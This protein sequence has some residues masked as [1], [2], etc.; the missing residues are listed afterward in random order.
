MVFQGRQV[1]VEITDS[2]SGDPASR[3]SDSSGRSFESP[4]PR[5]RI[6]GDKKFGD[7][8]FGDKRFGDKKTE[9]FHKKWR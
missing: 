3:P 1:R 9:R 2:R 7:K 4:R 5:K 6:Y 8:K